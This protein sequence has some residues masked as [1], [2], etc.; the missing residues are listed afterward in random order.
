MFDEGR[1]NQ[2]LFCYY[3]SYAQNRP[4]AGKFVPEDINPEL[5][6]HVIF[7]FADIIQ[8]TKL[9]ASGWNDLENGKDAG[10]SPIRCTHTLMHIVLL[11]RCLHARTC[12]AYL[13]VIQVCNTC[14]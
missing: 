3:S 6:T 9:K 2:K 14:M 10:K 11:K 1:S 7:A 13:Y 4:D 5:C 8:G 12:I